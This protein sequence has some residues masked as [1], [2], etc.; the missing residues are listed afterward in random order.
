MSHLFGE[1]VSRVRKFMTNLLSWFWTSI[2][3][4][5]TLTVSSTCKSSNLYILFNRVET[6][7]T[8][9][10]T[11]SGTVCVVVPCGEPYNG[12]TLT[13]LSHT[14]PCGEGFLSVEGN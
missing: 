6:S 14:K 7:L 5:L 2:S 3:P 9:Y 8:K 4:L 12:N 11:A 10:N 13:S 1:E